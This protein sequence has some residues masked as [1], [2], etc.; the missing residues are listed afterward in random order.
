[1][2]CI[3]SPQNLL[4]AKSF[5]DSPEWVIVTDA[6]SKNLTNSPYL[7]IFLILI[8]SVTEED[9]WWNGKKSPCINQKQ[10]YEIK[11]I[12]K[13]VWFVYKLLRS[14]SLPPPLPPP[15][16][17]F[18][19]NKLEGQNRCSAPEANRDEFCSSYRGLL[20]SKSCTAS[21]FLRN[22]LCFQKAELFSFPSILVEPLRFPQRLPNTKD[23]LSY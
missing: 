16:L 4:Y 17:P 22:A 7:F 2:V 11:L 19:F 5:L 14:F 23:P 1:M 13:K 6:V 9:T 3:P 8:K 18:L 10:W 12:R 15:S 20:C 21:G